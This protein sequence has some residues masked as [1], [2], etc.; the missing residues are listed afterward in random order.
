MSIRFNF[1]NLIHFLPL[2]VIGCLII[3]SNSQSYKGDITFYYEWHGNHGSCALEKSKKDPFHVA[4]LSRFF[5]KLPVNVTNP[6][7]HPYCSESYCVKVSGKRGSVVLKISDTCYGCKPH[8]IDVAHR[9]FPLLDDPNKGRV[10]MAWK[11][12]D[13][14]KNPPGKIRSDD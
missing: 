13:C 5:M 6:N 2:M 14:T 7:K 4:A 9:V 3:Q 8:D 1:G 12:V 10:P 11:F